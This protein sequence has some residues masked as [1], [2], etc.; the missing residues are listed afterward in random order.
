MMVWMDATA[1]AS[2]H[3][4]EHHGSRGRGCLY[5]DMV[6]E[7]MLMLKAVPEL[8]QRATDGFVNSLFRLLHVDL[9]SLD[10]SSITKWATTVIVN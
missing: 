4:V 7:T 9:V 1:I 2:W 3:N 10:H 6:T 5:S 8:P